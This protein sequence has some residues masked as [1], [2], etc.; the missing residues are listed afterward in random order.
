MS[1]AMSTGRSW[2]AILKTIPGFVPVIESNVILFGARDLD[3][4]EERQLQKSGVNV[5]GSAGMTPDNLLKTI[6]DALRNL[7]GRVTGIYLH[8]DMDVFSIEGGAANHFGVSGGLKP[9]FVEA[10]IAVVKKY[11]KL[12]ISMRNPKV[13]IISIHLM[14]PLFFGYHPSQSSQPFEQSVC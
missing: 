10:S 7:Q 5:S 1:L 13:R 14:S 8:I 4:E 12:C 2:K 6:E 3:K 11:F 9:E